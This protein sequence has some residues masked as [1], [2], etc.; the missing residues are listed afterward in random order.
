MSKAF[1]PLFNPFS[2]GGGGA[3]DGAHKGEAGREKEGT[4]R[5]Q[6]EQQAQHQPR[7]ASSQD[8]QTQ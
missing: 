7:G 4:G 8:Q 2:D 1:S 6:G 3:D 5:R